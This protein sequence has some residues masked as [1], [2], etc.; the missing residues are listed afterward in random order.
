MSRVV[1]GLHY[2]VTETGASPSSWSW[3]LSGSLCGVQQCQDSTT[4]VCS[5]LMFT[6]AQDWAVL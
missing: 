2:G 1:D 6:M 5:W 4:Q 3:R